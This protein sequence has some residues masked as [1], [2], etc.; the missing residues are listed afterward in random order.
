MR[1]TNEYEEDSNIN[2]IFIY[3]IIIMSVVVLAVTALVYLIN[4]PNEK[5]AGYALAKERA[6]NS[7]LSQAVEENEKTIDSL[8]SGS[9]LT[10]DELDIWTLPETGRETKKSSTA[11]DGKN[12]IVMNQTTGENLTENYQASQITEKLSGETTVYDATTKDSIE[13]ENEDTVDEH[14]NQTLVTYADKRE[15]WVDI[16]SGLELN[17]YDVS[18]YKY[19]KP[20]MKYFVDGK[21]ASFFGVDI[22]SKQGEVDFSK[23]KKAGCDYV[24][25]RI[26]QRGY[27]SGRIV[28]DENYKKNLEGAKKADLDIGVYFA[29]QAVTREEL[30]EEVTAL[31]DVIDAYSI[32]YPVVFDMEAVEDDLARSDALDVESRTRLAK[33]FLS[34]VEEAGYIPMLYGNKECLITKLNMEELE[35]YGVW[36]AQ[37]AD[38]PDYPYQYQMWQYTDSGTVSGVEEETRLSVSHID[39]SRQ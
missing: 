8:V 23:L 4:K 35:E 27:S 21:Q 39:Y 24:M 34:E 15:E 37:K 9:K 22:S 12:G 19:S 14:A 18:K 29:S 26:G 11:T 10:S 28:M 13:E 25:I 33:L 17:T 36:L 38:T 30:L 7:T 5:G 20:E 32:S 2:M 1:Y 31:L 6:A 16:N 3:M